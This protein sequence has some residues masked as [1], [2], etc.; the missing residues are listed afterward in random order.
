MN[1]FTK[2]LKNK[3]YL[4]GI[5]FIFA[6]IIGNAIFFACTFS[7]ICIIKK[8][9]TNLTDEKFIPNQSCKNKLNLGNTLIKS[10]NNIDIM[11]LTPDNHFADKRYPLI[12]VY[13]PAGRSAKKSEK[14]YKNITNYFTKHGFI[15]AYISHIP[16]DE[17]LIRDYKIVLELIKKQYCISN[18]IT[19]L[20]HSDGATIS[21]ILGYRAEK[22]RYNNIIMSASGISGKAL[23]NIKCPIN[24]SSY[25]IFHNKRD[26]LFPYYGSENYN[27]LKKCFS[28]SKEDT[29]SL[30]GC[31]KPKECGGNRIQICY[32]NDVHN[33][34]NLEPNSLLKFI[35]GEDK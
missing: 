8:P 17:Q 15:L 20:G 18:E 5:F 10:K 9:N 11:I 35:T 19:L 4:L 3:V 13:A 22:N 31:L 7:D 26:L 30:N 25:L 6:W 16:L 28:C 23:E 12:I 2:L 1:M 21:G 32:N 14:F 27:W 34:W 33:K 24:K 29:T